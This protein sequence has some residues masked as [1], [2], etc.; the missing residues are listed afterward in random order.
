MYTNYDLKKISRNNFMYLGTFF[1]PNTLYKGR[2]KKRHFCTSHP[3]IAGTLKA[4]IH[5][6]GIAFFC[7]TPIHLWR[8][9]PI[10][11]SII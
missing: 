11:M 10:W 2:D 8:R 3:H 9:M 6:I 4:R 5:I 7:S 1:Y